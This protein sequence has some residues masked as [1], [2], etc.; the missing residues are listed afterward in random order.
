MIATGPA[1]QPGQTQSA[2]QTGPQ[3]AAPTGGAVDAGSNQATAEAAGLE[4]GGDDDLSLDGPNAGL[5]LDGLPITEAVPLALAHGQNPTV[6]QWIAE[7]PDSDAE[8]AL[9]QI[10]GLAQR[11]LDTLWPVGVG[12]VGLV[13][14]DTAFLSAFAAQGVEVCVS[15]EGPLSFKLSYQ[16]TVRQ[17]ARAGAAA[18]GVAGE[19]SAAVGAELRVA[20]TSELAGRALAPFL[21][22]R[23]ALLLDGLLRVPLVI[24]AFACLGLAEL[25]RASRVDAEAAAVTE[26]SAQMAVD[27]DDPEALHP[28]IR[29]A[30]HALPVGLKVDARLE[31][32]L[33]AG[34]TLARASGGAWGLSLTGK[35]GGLARLGGALTAALG[36]LRFE[37]LG[38]MAEAAPQAELTLRFTLSGGAPE[39]GTVAPAPCTVQLGAAA[40]PEA[41]GQ[42]V[43]RT[44]SV[45]YPSWEALCAAFERNPEGLVG[46]E[47]LPGVTDQPWA[48]SEVLKAAPPSALR[49]ALSLPL[50]APELVHAAPELH[51]TLIH[52]SGGAAGAVLAA[53]TA[54]SLT[55]EALIAPEDLRLAADLGLC[56]PAG[57]TAVGAVRWAADAVLAARTGSPFAADAAA[58]GADL[59]AAFWGTPALTEA[60]VQ[61]TVKVELS[62]GVAVDSPGLPEGAAGLRVGGGLRV[63]LAAPPAELARLQRAA[64]GGGALG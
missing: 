51:R 61:G 47:P 21:G 10:E 31:A 56:A 29:A 62:T 6:Q 20:V 13:G 54:I 32:L 23:A 52:L 24:P 38:P 4:G 46:G 9:M 28:A 64:A 35:V 1:P 48:L 49:V 25:L 41:G 53:G 43:A 45:D 59:R 14:A 39:P 11:A 5:L 16:N 7:L 26:A 2:P 60:R 50:S 55:G 27:L 33:S 40:V 8:A 22:L 12:L 3:A 57:S 63:D 15:R 58:W 44:H 18:E 34:A 36:P 30:L 37:L 19:A 42:S 17:G